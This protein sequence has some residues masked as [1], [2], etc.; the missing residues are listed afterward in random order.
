MNTRINN[1]RTIAELRS[2]ERMYTLNEVEQRLL[3]EKQMEIFQRIREWR[4]ENEQLGLIPDF[5]DTV[6]DSGAARVV[7]V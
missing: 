6:L 7:Y 2:I 5:T 1:C 3:Y 4:V